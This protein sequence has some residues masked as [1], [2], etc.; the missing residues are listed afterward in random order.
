MN[1]NFLWENAITLQKKS[2]NPPFPELALHCHYPKWRSLRHRWRILLT[3][4]YLL[5][6]SLS[7]C[8][9]VLGSEHDIVLLTKHD[10]NIHNFLQLK[11][12]KHIKSHNLC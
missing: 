4:S 5:I 11:C 2:A 9:F 6:S 7:R 3:D 8:K 10:S 12:L 1:P